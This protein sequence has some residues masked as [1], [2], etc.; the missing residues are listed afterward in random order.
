[1]CVSGTAPVHELKR[2]PPPFKQTRAKRPPPRSSG[3]SGTV[4]T[5]NGFPSASPPAVSAFVTQHVSS[6][7]SAAETD[8][9]S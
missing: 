3:A 9:T 6:L 7:H 1:M 4:Q 8:R 5:L 2:D